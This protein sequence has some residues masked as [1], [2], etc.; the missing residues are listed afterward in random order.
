MDVGGRSVIICGLRNLRIYLRTETRSL[1]EDVDGAFAPLDLS[2]REDYVAFLQAHHAALAPLE[3]ARAAAGW[4]SELPSP[5]DAA[6]LVAADLADLGRRP[7]AEV[8]LAAGFEPVGA[9]YVL[10]GSRMGNKFLRQQ[11]HQ[12]TDGRPTRYVDSEPLDSFGRDYLVALK[13]MDAGRDAGEV[14]A[15]ARCAFTMFKRASGSIMGSQQ[16]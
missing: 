16:R 7:G 8:D 14:L 10:A 2:R 15:G 13:S 1:H 9:T 11:V 12:A 3:R 6:P 5:L 4:P